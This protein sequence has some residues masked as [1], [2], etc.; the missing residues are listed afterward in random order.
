MSRVQGKQSGN[1]ES[2]ACRGKRTG[3]SH[4]SPKEGT[5]DTGGDLLMVS[6]ASRKGKQTT[7]STVAGRDHGSPPSRVSQSLLLPELIYKSQDKEPNHCSSSCPPLA[8]S[9]LGRLQS[10]SGEANRTCSI[11]VTDSRAHGRKADSFQTRYL[12]YRTHTVQQL[13]FDLFPFLSSQ[14]RQEL[15]VIHPDPSSVTLT[16]FPSTLKRLYSRNPDSLDSGIFNYKRQ[17]QQLLGEALKWQHK[18]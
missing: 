18:S 10:S 1:V 14:Y 11:S 4:K 2:Q 15:P 6:E 3:Q 8:Y 13:H 5:E 16:Q 12:S 9:R 7:K 17:K